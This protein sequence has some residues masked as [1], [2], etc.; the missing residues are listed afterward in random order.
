MDSSVLDLIAKI[1]ST[2]WGIIVGAFFSLGGVVLTN[3]ANIKNLYAQFAN[4][5]EIKNRE[6]ELSVKKEVYLAAAEAAHAGIISIAKLANL[7]YP[8]DKIFDT[9]EEKSP[10]IGKVH[11]IGDADTIEAVSEF[12]GELGAVFAKLSLKRAQ[13]LSTRDN[14]L[15]LSNLRAKFEKDRDATLELMKQHNIEGVVD[16]RRWEV[17]QKNFEIEQDTVSKFLEDQ[18]KLSY[19]LETKRLVFAGECVSECSR[20]G[21]LLVPALLSARK[22]LDLPIGEDK[23]REIIQNSLLKQDATMKEVVQQAQKTIQSLKPN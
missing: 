13:L 20:L 9:Y 14:I 2:F 19:E 22:E 17:I 8:N 12:T 7:G 10:A 3:R 16:K 18:R 1:P 15:G 23:Y 11:L 5:R 6:R 21:K 4:E